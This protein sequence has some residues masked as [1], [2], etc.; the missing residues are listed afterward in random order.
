LAYDSLWQLPGYAYDQS[1]A[2][3]V[4]LDLAGRPPRLDLIGQKGATLF[5][6]YRL[7][8]R[9]LRQC[10][11]QKEKER[12]GTLDPEKLDPPGVLMLMERPKDTGP[13][14]DARR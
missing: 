12:Q 8:R 3:K 1:G 11:W 6:A 9:Q 14:L 5:C 7:D 4:R 2:G 13:V 10:W